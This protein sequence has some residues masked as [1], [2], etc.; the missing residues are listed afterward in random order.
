[1]ADVTL[2]RD[3]DP[4]ATGGLR[5]KVRAKTLVYVLLTLFAAFYLIPILIVLLN[6]FRELPEINR[7]GFFAIPRSF[8]VQPWNEALNTFCVVGTC[9]GI[10][11]FFLNSILMAV[12]ATAI[13]TAIGLVNGYILSMWRFRGS[14]WLFGF[15]TLGVFLPAQMTL[16]PWAYILG[17]A[18]LTNTITGLVLIHTVQGLSFTTLFCRNYFVNI[19]DDLIKA[20]RIDGAG[21]WRIFRRIVLPLSPP[22]VIV[23]V[24]WQFTGIW[25]DFIYGVIFSSGDK[26]PIT[27][28][29][30]ALT[31][32][33]TSVR[34]H[35]VE[36]AAVLMA[37]VPPLL[38][39][40]FGGKYFMRGL[41]QGAVK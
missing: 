3:F 11:P 30:I 31:A 8:S 37:A 20:A 25:N 12:P 16:L 39:Y 29:L 27:S 9:E 13:S 2:A 23:T 24:I 28:A 32:G 41:T 6:S 15:I 19:P 21:F 10:R 36:A 33:A 34:Y 4:L 5:R 7:T 35:N 22:I 1:M 38:V 18:G 40:L 17:N 26:Q 14:E